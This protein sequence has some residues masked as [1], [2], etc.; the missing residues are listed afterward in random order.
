[1]RECEVHISLD[2]NLETSRSYYY[3]C[4][5]SHY[6]N[7]KVFKLDS[8]VVRAYLVVRGYFVDSVKLN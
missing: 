8:Q 7:A 3:Q 4:L 1:M 6:N 5:I 2:L